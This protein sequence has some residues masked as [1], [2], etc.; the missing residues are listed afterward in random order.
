MLTQALRQRQGVSSSAI[1]RLTQLV[2]GGLRCCDKPFVG[3][4]MCSSR[5]L[6]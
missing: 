1:A 5:T 3:A 4:G 2:P 6:C